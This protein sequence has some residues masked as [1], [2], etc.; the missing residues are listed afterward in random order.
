MQTWI[1]TLL[2]LATPAVL[3]GFITYF[4]CRSRRVAIEM[5]LKATQREL[6]TINERLQHA[7]VE[8]KTALESK[9]RIEQEAKRLPELE[10]QAAEL[11][12]EK[13]ELKDQVTEMKRERDLHEGMAQWL[14]RAEDR[15]RE[16]FQSLASRALESNADQF[17]QR[18]HSQLDNIFERAQGDWSQQKTEFKKLVEPLEK[19]LEVLD[20]QVRD[21][22][23]KREGAYQKLQQELQQL[24]HTHEELQTSTTNLA[25]A[26]KTPGVRGAWGELQ[27]RRVVEMAGMMDR[28]DFIGQNGKNAERPDMIVHMPNKGILPVDAKTPMGAYLEGMETADDQLRKA[29]LDAHSGAMRQRIQELADP[30]YRQQFEH[31]AELVV[32][33]VPNEA[34]LGVAFEQD[35]EL[36]EYAIQQ[37]VLLTTPVTLLALLKAVA[38]GWQQHQVV[39]NAHQIALQGKQLYRRLNTFLNHLGELG[40]RLDQAVRGYNKAVVSLESRVLPAARRLR[41]VGAESMGLTSP[42]PIEHQAIA[43][44][45]PDLDEEAED[46]SIKLPP[47]GSDGRSRGG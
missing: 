38:Y 1:I 19:T 25:H 10:R 28:V 35:P 24:A 18:A 44:P 9:A 11:R 15:L 6:R 4:F 45:R 36:L 42:A 3:S 7:G 31:T 47:T 39:E 32:M 30:D 26:L 33:F 41:E 8:L 22:E 40:R 17:L 37:G 20:G 21:L 16:T 12:N 27:L 34:C 29:K 14:G 23:Q 43:P 2:A 46:N 5:G 13:L